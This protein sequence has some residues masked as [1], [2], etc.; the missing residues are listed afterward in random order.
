ML[1]RLVDRVEAH[2]AWVWGAHVE[3]LVSDEQPL[4]VRSFAHS[5]E[6]DRNPER[7]EGAREVEE[8]RACGGGV[9][10]RDGREVEEDEAR[11]RL[12]R[13]VRARV[14]P[15]AAASAADKRKGRSRRRAIHRRPSDLAAAKVGWQGGRLVA[16]AAVAAPLAEEGRLAIVA[17]PAV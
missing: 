8:A 16:T 10:S 2:R 5:A 12:G 15:A 11:R 4:R 6:C 13:C 9:Q 14:A 7:R 3:D 1:E 17:P